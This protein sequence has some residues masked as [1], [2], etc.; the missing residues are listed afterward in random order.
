MG[1][2]QLPK[3][4]LGNFWGESLDVRQRLLTSAFN[5]LRWADA[6]FSAQ[7]IHAPSHISER[8]LC[9]AF[10]KAVADGLRNPAES[11]LSIAGNYS[12]ALSKLP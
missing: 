9:Q 6:S 2:S 4:F 10:C 1:F 5:K 11:N 12:A 8:E 3:S 7:R